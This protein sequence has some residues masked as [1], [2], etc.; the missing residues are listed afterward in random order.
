[1]L[2]VRSGKGG[3]FRSVPLNAEVR[4]AVKDYLA[5]RPETDED[6]LFIGQRGAGLKPRMV[7]YLISTYARLAGLEGVSPHTLRHSF[8]KHSLE[9]G[10]NLVEVSR[11]AGHQRLDTTAIYTTPSFKDLEQAVAKLGRD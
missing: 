7:E 10:A 1:M 4:A 6:H 5:V 3:K 8:C 9:A 11:L 2:T